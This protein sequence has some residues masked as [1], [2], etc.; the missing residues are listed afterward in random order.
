MPRDSAK[1]FFLIRLGDWVVRAF[2][3]THTIL[4][5]L[6]LVIGVAVGYAALAYRVWVEWIQEVAFV[7]E[8]EKLVA[9]AGA[10]PDW[11]VFAVPV[12][13]SLI[14]MA[15]LKWLVPGHRP[16]AVA[17]AIEAAALRDGRIDARVGLGSALATATAL[18]AGASTGREGP[19]VHAG[20]TVASY[21]AQKLHLTP[22][23]ARTLLGCGVASAIAAS[24]NAPI[25]GVIFAL[26]VVVGHYALHAL[27]PVVIAGVAG[28]V[29]TRI[30]VGDYPAF[31]VPPLSI[32][33][34]WEFPA[35][36]LLGLICAGVAV[37][38]SKLVM[39]TDHWRKRIWPGPD[40]A[41][42]PVAGILI[43]A[44]ALWLPQILG[45]SYETTDAALRGNLALW[46]LLALIPM[47]ML[48]TSVCL[49]CRF[50][51]GVF[52]PSLF[53][54]AMTGAAFGLIV[55]AVFPE[56]ASQTGVYAI[57][58]MAAVSS[59]VLGAPISTLLII[60]ELTGNYEVTIAVMLAGA[61]ASLIAS[62]IYKPSIFIVQLEQRGIRLE[63]GKATHLLKATPVRSI[64]IRDFVPVRETDSMDYARRLMLA[65]EG[66]LPVIDET[67]ELKGV[68][69]HTSLPDEEADEAVEGGIMQVAQFYRQNPTAVAASDCL[70]DALKLLERL[71]EDSVPVVQ[72]LDRPLVVGI[73]RLRDV[74]QAYNRAL[75]DAQG[76]TLR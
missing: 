32:A 51:S 10:L 48:A 66:V 53:L 64:M 47:K 24:F 55:T 25:A 5:L 50:G 74:L 44:M 30:H 12:L 67:G 43:G 59:A 69:S 75:L 40:W 72:S 15:I 56:Q 19:M 65:H 26:E 45:V 39:L 54:G 31:T 8:G 34:F 9:A 27:A 52:S 6:S 49:A 16:H 7:A 3:Y 68:L 42:P 33:S 60:F 63:G 23:I 62:L 18:G 73:L 70:E 41:L 20:A 38:F 17:E 76:M 28:T 1:R 36:L 58:G 4:F 46:V 35:F 37:G 21:I 71:G 61:M 22:A 2:R 13:G 29:V 14:V 57:V 11:R